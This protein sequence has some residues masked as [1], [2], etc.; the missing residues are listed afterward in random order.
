MAMKYTCFICG[1][2][3]LDSRCDWDICP[4]CFWEDDV[5]VEEED[6]NSPANS[7]LVSV[8]Q[9]NF[10]LFGAVDKKSINDVRKPLPNE[11]LD[12]NW[13][14]LKRAIELVNEKRSDEGEG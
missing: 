12:M 1:Y 11:T 9:A 6:E 7:L 2:K 14:P 8:A 5:W 4:V 10:M 13:S 3:T